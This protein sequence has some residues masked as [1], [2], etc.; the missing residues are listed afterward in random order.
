MT[1]HKNVTYEQVRRLALQVF[2]EDKD[3]LNAWW[4]AKRDEF[5]NKSPYEVVRDG[6]GRWLM[7]YLTRCML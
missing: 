1:R 6:R 5:D 2:G 4:M 3:K 7:D